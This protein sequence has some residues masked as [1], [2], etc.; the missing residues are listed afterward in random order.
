MA[1]LYCDSDGEDKVQEAIKEKGTYDG[2]YTKIV[3]G[4]LVTSGYRCDKCNRP[5]EKDDIAYYVAHLTK[6]N[7]DSKGEADYFN[8]KT[9]KS[10]IY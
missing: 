4:Q 3:I 5:L 8:L 2:E 6:S 9:V 1:S 7:R 10:T